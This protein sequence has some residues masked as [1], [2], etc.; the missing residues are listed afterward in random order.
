[1][2]SPTTKERSVALKARMQKLKEKLKE[3]SEK[4]K[5]FIQ[6]TTNKKDTEKI[7][8]K[9]DTAKTAK[10]DSTQNDIYAAI[11][12]KMKDIQKP[13]ESV[14]TL[15]SKAPKRKSKTPPTKPDTII[16]IPP[17]KEFVQKIQTPQITGTK[18]KYTV[19]MAVVRH[20]YGCHNAIRQLRKSNIID[21]KVSM[22]DLD[23]LSDPELT[24][25]GVDASI[26]NGCIIAKLL[27]NAAKLTNNQMFHIDR[28]NIV[29]CSPLIRSMETAYYMTRRWKNPPQKIYVFP[30]LRERDETS[31]DKYSAYSRKMIETEPSY[32]MKSIEEQK[33]YLQSEGILQYFDFSFVETS[34]G[35]K[36]PGD[37]EVFVNWFANMFL[38]RV[39]PN[40]EHINMMIVTHAGVINDFIGRGVVNNSGFLVNLEIPVKTTQIQDPKSFVTST[41]NDIMLFDKYLPESFFDQYDN[42]RFNTVDYYCPS[43]RCGK[44]CQS[45]D[46]PNKELS[47]YQTACTVKDTEI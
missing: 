30:F 21:K 20:G 24:P 3:R 40:Q 28:M 44:L 13:Q 47:K 43:G 25:L 27:K 19:N 6:E 33:M 4:E 10:K 46:F 31:E 14:L 26:H 23:I 42:P 17:E 2:L 8:K 5:S 29:G 12:K 41:A 45:T 34:L 39:Q 18:K 36:D 35:R 15:P 38:P 11:E 1:M 22:L 7:G 32:A 37:I 9:D 16:E